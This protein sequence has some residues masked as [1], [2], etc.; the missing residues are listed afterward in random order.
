VQ[1]KFTH[2][3]K[4]FPLC[5]DMERTRGGFAASCDT[6]VNGCWIPMGIHD[7]TSGT[8]IT[9]SGFPCQGTQGEDNASLAG[10][11]NRGATDMA[12]KKATKKTT[13][14][15]SAKRSPKKPARAKS[16][17]RSP[18]KAVA[19]KAKKSSKR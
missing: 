14:K 9:P 18:K 8:R 10:T 2:G 19:R 11:R 6:D 12:T 4:Q 1:T 3:K 17:K 15:K 7:D 13:K 5:K 16:V